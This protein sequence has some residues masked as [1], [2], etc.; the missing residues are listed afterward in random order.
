V[1]QL[2]T[3]ATSVCG[4]SQGTEEGRRM[5]DS[6][7]IQR[8]GATPGPQ[9]RAWT[10]KAAARRA[11]ANKRLTVSDFGRVEAGIANWLG[12]GSALL[13]PLTVLTRHL[14]RF[15]SLLSLND[16]KLSALIAIL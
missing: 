2:L 5:C 16:L 7:T 12:G 3:K 6:S 8:H 13:Y 10:A 4:W 15:E 14:Q 9:K 1:A 11:S